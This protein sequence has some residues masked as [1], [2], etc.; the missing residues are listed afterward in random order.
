MPT[1]TNEHVLLDLGSDRTGR[2][3][4]EISRVGVSPRVYLCEASR[5]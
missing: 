2:D 5:D 1:N 4:I 3:D